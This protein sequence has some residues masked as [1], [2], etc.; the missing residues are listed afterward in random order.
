ME[1]PKSYVVLAFTGIEEIKDAFHVR[2]LE[3]DKPKTKLPLAVRVPPAVKLLME[4]SF[5]VS[6]VP[7]IMSV[8]SWFTCVASAVLPLVNMYV[9]EIKPMSFPHVLSCKSFAL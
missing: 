4:K 2:V 7:L 8:K 3:D 1:V 6:E 5:V 9:T